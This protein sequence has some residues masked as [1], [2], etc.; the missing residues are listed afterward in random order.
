MSVKS[1]MPSENDRTF[2]SLFHR[3]ISYVTQ[4]LTN[5]LH[6]ISNGLLDPRAPS[7]VST[8]VRDL[9]T[10][11]LEMG[12]QRA[13]VYLEVCHYGERIRPGDKFKDESDYDGLDA[14]V[15]LMTKPCMVRVGDGREDLV[16]QKVIEK[17]DFVSTRAGY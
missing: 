3:N 13:H 7:Q 15:D 17:G 9:G 5:T 11:A 12:S 8:L 1:N 14:Q 6:Q 16:S 10:L 2:A 4:Q